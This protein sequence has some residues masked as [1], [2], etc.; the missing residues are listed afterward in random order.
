MTKSCEAYREQ[1]MMVCGRCG[2]Q[3]SVG[4]SDRPECNPSA[5]KSLRQNQNIIRVRQTHGLQRGKS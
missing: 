3:W 1:D 4:D 2:L 5:T